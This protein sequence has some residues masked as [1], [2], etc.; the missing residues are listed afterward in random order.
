V[1]AC[2]QQ[3]LTKLQGFPNSL[4]E[5][6][7]GLPTR[8]LFRPRCVDQNAINWWMG[9]GECAMVMLNGKDARVGAHGSPMHM[10]VSQIL[11]EEAARLGCHTWEVDMERIDQKWWQKAW[12]SWG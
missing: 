11:E 6:F 8:I 10:L 2:V 5:M 7:V 3:V 4:M 12:L 9:Y 1:A